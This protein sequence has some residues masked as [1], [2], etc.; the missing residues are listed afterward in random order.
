MF[1]YTLWICK[2]HRQE[3]FVSK[4]RCPRSETLRDRAFIGTSFPMPWMAG[5][6]PISFPEMKYS[7]FGEW[8]DAAQ[9][10]PWGTCEGSWPGPWPKHCSKLAVSSGRPS[11]GCPSP[12]RS[13][14]GTE[15]LSGIF[16]PPLQLCPVG[17]A[18]CHAARQ[19]RAA[20]GRLTFQ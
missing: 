18:P 7:R 15:R 10:H 4:R 11:S 16:P 9:G 19:H 3:F 5:S 14:A 20:P 8:Y 2:D 12:G 1:L 6:I 13:A 17:M